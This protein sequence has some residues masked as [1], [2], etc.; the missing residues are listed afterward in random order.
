MTEPSREL[1]ERDERV[2]AYLRGTNFDQPSGIARATG[3]SVQ[4]VTGS[5]ARLK[6]ERKARVHRHWAGNAWEAIDRG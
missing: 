5:L 2:L 6:R 4:A 3:D 1:S